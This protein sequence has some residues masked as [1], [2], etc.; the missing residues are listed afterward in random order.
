M[1]YFKWSHN[2]IQ[3]IL[4][5]SHLC[6]V[7]GKEGHRDVESSSF[8]LSLTETILYR[9][10][11]PCCQVAGDGELRGAVDQVARF[12]NVVLTVRELLQLIL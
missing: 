8:L 10:L 6:Q 7:E 4:I 2:A 9:H 5:T 3:V 1:T 11:N 12:C